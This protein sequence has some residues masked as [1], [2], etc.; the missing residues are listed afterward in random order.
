MTLTS[1]AS[2]TVASCH[3]GSILCCAYRDNRYI[4]QRDKN[5]RVTIFP[6][7]QAPTKI[8]LQENLTSEYF[9]AQKFPIYGST[10]TTFTGT[11]LHTLLYRLATD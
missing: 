1:L 5:F 3:Q 10:Y 9:Y 8:Y 4:I 11:G 2:L 6:W 7:V